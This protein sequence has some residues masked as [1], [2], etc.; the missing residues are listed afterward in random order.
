MN[1]LQITPYF[2]P[3][4]SYGGIPRV[5]YDLSIS[6][7]RS[8]N[9]VVTLTTDVLSKEKR[10]KK[11]KNVIEGIETYYFP[12]ISN[13]LAYHYQMY[14]PIGM[15]KWLLNNLE[16]IDIA[17]FHGHRHFLNNI[18]L[19]ALVKR[20]IPY[21]LSAH[22]TALKIER[23]IALKS[24]FDFFWGNKIIQNASHFIAVSEKEV[25]QYGSIGISRKKVSIVNNGINIEAYQELPEKGVFRERYNLKD[26]KIVLYL[27]KITPRKGLD[28]LVHAIAAL[29]SNDIVLAVVGND[30]GFKARVDK[31]ISEYR[32]KERVIFTGVLVDREKLSAYIDSDVLVY[33]STLEIFGLVPFES[34]MC[35]TPVIVTDDCGCGEIIYKI[36][37]GEIV[38]YGEVEGLKNKILYVLKNKEEAQRKVQKGQEFIKNN[39][40]WDTI[41]NE[42]QKVYEKVYFSV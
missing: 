8:G 7:V 28:I 15:R 3:A 39:L 29:P 41:S 21:I 9:K 34:I 10:Y 36:G 24:I 4:W 17:H 11:R 16:D 30:M 27:G 42:I 40:K 33:P 19:K 32:I 18:A 13:A 31:L 22:G 20:K 2:Y 26:K 38:K 23:R 37:A 14:L 12:N 25:E 6:L 35:G 1:I 5:V